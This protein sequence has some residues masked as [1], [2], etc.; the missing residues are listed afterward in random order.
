MAVIQCTPD[1]GKTSR[2]VYVGTSGWQYRHW[3]GRFYPSK[4][5]QRLWLAE[6]VSRF[7]T[8]EV[9]NSFYR[10]PAEETFDKWRVAAPN[11]FLFAVK[12]SRYI[13]HIRRLR[14][15][16]DPVDLFWA[17]AAHLRSNLGPVLF[18]LPP[19]FKADPALLAEFL[20]VLPAGMRAAFEFRDDSW[21]RD[22]VLAALE[23]AGAAWVLAD[24]PGWRVPDIVSSGWS[25]VRFHQGRAAHPGYAASKLARWAD[26][27]V[28]SGA[29][30][31]FVYFNND[32]L[33]AAPE[34]ARTLIRLLAR[35]GA[36]LPTT[37]AA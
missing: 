26:R 30:D 31:T 34:D 15:P 25:Y 17:R 11:G 27:I 37:L 29:T 24:R 3:K 1:G 19:N 7:P 20:T 12:A 2:M 9:N 22:D 4:V 8:V 14:E 10:L 21:R 6:Y 28:A 18:Q 16:K 23:R 5:P 32:W 33:G 36:D 13:T 35:R